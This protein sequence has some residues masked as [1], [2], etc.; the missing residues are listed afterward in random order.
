MRVASSFFPDISPRSI[1]TVCAAMVDGVWSQL[2]KAVSQPSS[3]ASTTPFQQTRSTMVSKPLGITF[4]TLE[5]DI[6]PPCARYWL[7]YAFD[8]ARL[9]RL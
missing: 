6:R 8:V 1:Y 7:V 4:Y 3:L 2:L 5:A 9:V